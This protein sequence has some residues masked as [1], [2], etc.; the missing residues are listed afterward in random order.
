MDPKIKRLMDQVKAHLHEMY[1]EGIKKVIVYGS[2]A[3][4]E[5]TENSDVDVLVLVDQSLNPRE[6]DDSLSNLLYDMLLDEGELVSVIVI[7]E[8]FFENHSLPFML[9][10]RKEGVTI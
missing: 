1:G 7:P 3:R 9:N 10:V 2:H 6:V 4:G 8:D 5:A